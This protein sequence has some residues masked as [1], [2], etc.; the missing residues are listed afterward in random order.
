MEKVHGNLISRL[1][2]Q[3]VQCLVVADAVMGRECKN[4]NEKG[5]GGRAEPTIAFILLCNVPR[6]M[7]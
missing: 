1:W 2:K 5:K 7:A 4:A 3:L 6:H